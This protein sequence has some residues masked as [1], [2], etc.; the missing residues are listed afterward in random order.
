MALSIYDKPAESVHE[1][2]YVPVPFQELLQVSKLAEERHNQVQQ[3]EDQLHNALLSIKAIPGNATRRANEISQGYEQKINDIASSHKGDWRSTHDALHSLGRDI[4]N[5]FA[6]GEVSDLQNSYASYNATLGEFSKGQDSGRY[7]G[8]E[9]VAKHNLITRPYLGYNKAIGEGRQG[10]RFAGGT[11]GKY[12][13]IGKD[14]EALIHDWKPDQTIGGLVRG[15]DG[16]FYSRETNESV[17]QSE[18]ATTVLNQ[19]KTDPKYQGQLNDM[20]VYQNDI[21]HTKGIDYSGNMLKKL[22]DNLSYK[23]AYNKT[24]IEDH[25]NPTAEKD[26]E[27]NQTLSFTGNT[28]VIDLHDNSFNDILDATEKKVRDTNVAGLGYGVDE[29]GVANRQDKSTEPNSSISPTYNVN[30]LSKDQQAIFNNVAKAIG[31]SDRDEDTK[32][33]NVNR[34]MKLLQDQQIS[35]PAE[36]IPDI[37]YPSGKKGA[38]GLT[39]HVFGENIIKNKKITGDYINRAFFDPSTGKTLTGTEFSDNVISKQDKDTPIKVVNKYS[40]K[41]PFPAMTG[42]DKFANSYQ[43]VVGNKQYVMSAANEE[44]VTDNKGNKHDLNVPARIIN[45]LADSKRVGGIPKEISLPLGNKATSTYTTNGFELVPQGSSTPIRDEN[46][47]LPK[48]ESQAL[49]LLFQQ[50]IEPSSKP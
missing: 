1:N 44:W 2:Q 50:V 32:N 13:D 42:D 15:R 31:V 39:D 3:Q 46:G 10:V 9:D 16:H 14:A 11:V 35:T 23:A 41:N 4:A 5:N 38:E 21:N 19:L 30:K 33:V 40:S 20:N 17:D 43:V 28:P 47:E 45:K 12:Y 7:E 37:K 8:Q 34:Y 25:V 27:D 26:M 36:S 48:D 29:A 24:S 6:R 49:Q 18:V 22:S